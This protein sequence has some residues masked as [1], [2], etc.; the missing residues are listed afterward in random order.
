MA[1]FAQLDEHNEVLQV[2]VIHNND[3]LDADG[4]ESEA[5]G[6]AFCQT[7]YPGTDWK[8]TSYN[9]NIRKNYAGVGYTYDQTRDAFIPPQ[10]YPSWVLDE[11]TCH[12]NAPT[13]I[14]VD[15]KF[16]SWNEAQLA[17]IEN[18]ID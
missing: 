6:V 13:P 9:G 8:Q 16:Y 1:H 14:P 4:N 12:W 5:A 10:P 15:G 18:G 7:L 17:W 11:T 3:C 2:I